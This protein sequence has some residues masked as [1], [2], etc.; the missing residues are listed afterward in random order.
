MKRRPITEHLRRWNIPARIVEMERADSPA[1][2]RASALIVIV[3]V[4]A[5]A[6]LIIAAAT[7]TLFGGR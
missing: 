5:V 1:P 6:E 4:A 2:G 7:V 3:G